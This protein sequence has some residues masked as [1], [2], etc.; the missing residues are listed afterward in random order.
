MNFMYVMI[1]MSEHWTKKFKSDDSESEYSQKEVD[2]SYLEDENSTSSTSEHSEYSYS[3]SDSSSSSNSDSS[4]DEES[5]NVEEE[6]DIE[7]DLES[8]SSMDIEMID[9]TDLN[10]VLLQ[11]L[12]DTLKYIKENEDY[13]LWHDVNNFGKLRDKYIKTKKLTEI[14]KERYNLLPVWD[15]YIEL[16][17]WYSENKVAFNTREYSLDTIKEFAKKG[18]K[19]FN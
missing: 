12:K 8:E 10:P 11:A 19:I 14:Q 6:S 16:Y 1:D 9:S 3:G 13:P 18:P 5:K 2:I 17:K 15:S 4:S 7:S